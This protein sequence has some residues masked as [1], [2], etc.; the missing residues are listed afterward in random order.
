MIIYTPRFCVKDI[1]ILVRNKIMRNDISS[2][3]KGLGSLKVNDKLFMVMKSFLL[4]ML[5]LFSSNIKADD[6]SGI[7]LKKTSVHYNHNALLSTSIIEN[8]V[9]VDNPINQNSSVSGAVVDSYTGEPIPGALINIEGN[10]QST[11]T[12]S[13]GY[14]IL[15]NLIEGNINIEISSTGYSL[16]QKSFMLKGGTNVK[17]GTIKMTRDFDPYADDED[18]MITFD[19]DLFD[20]ESGSNQTIG[21]LSGASSDLYTR[22]SG[23]AFGVARFRYRGYDSRYTDVYINGLSFN[24]PSRGRFNFS[25][26]GGMN[27]AFRNK[28]VVNGADPSG[29]SFGDV[30]GATNIVT[31]AS[32]FAPGL[33][34]SV[35]YTNRNYNWRGMVTYSTGLLPNGWAMTASA[36]ARYAHEGAIDGTFYNSYG[37]FLSADKVLNDINTFSFTVFGSPTQR[38]QAAASYEECYRLTGNNLYNP[39]WGYQQ[40]KKRNARVVESFDPTFTFNWVW[41][42]LKNT[43]VNTG[44]GFRYSSYASTALN[45]YDTSDP[46]PDYYRRLPSYFSSNPSLQEYYTDQWE[47]NVDFRQINWDDLYQVNYLGRYENQMTGTDKG[48]T[49]IVEKRHSNQTNL[50]FGS[51]IDTD[52]NHFMGLQGGISFRWTKAD[53]YKT[54]DDLLG[55]EFWLDIDQFSESDFPDNSDILQNNM[56]NPNFKARKDDKFGY[57]YSIYNIITNLW[58]QNTIN[59]PQWEVYYG[60]SLR[61]YTFWRDGHMRN[62]RAPNNSYGKGDINQFINGAFKAGATYKFDGNNY[63]TLNFIGENKAPYFNNAYISAKI[64]DTTVPNLKSENIYSIDAS[65]RFAFNKLKGKVSAFYTGFNDQTE[66]S[67]F[68]H[69]A[70]QT[71]VNYILTGVKK[72]FKGLELGLSYQITPEIKITAVGTW[73]KYLYKNRPTGI[74]NYE[75]GSLPDTSQVVYLKNYHVGGTPQLAGNIGIN[76]KAPKLWFFEINLSLFEDAYVDLA[77][78][79]RTQ[80]ITDITL[81]GNSESEV[82]ENYN[83]AVNQL[84]HQDKLNGGLMLNVSIGKLI[85]LDR[86]NSLSINVT[87]NNITNNKNLQTGGYEQGRLPLSN[88][89]IDT[90]NLNKYPNKYYY[91]QGFNVFANVG[92]RF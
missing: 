48:S 25:A 36:I 86:K 33:R 27:N 77:P 11:T 92:Y 32:K 55:G 44:L 35:G 23:F 15:N 18:G 39:N 70:F 5:F 4:L 14:F 53:Y 43:T 58:I 40:G 47:N 57:N 19:E 42:P 28:N 91:S 8:A 13:K 76:W 88:G 9:P 45:W 84:K 46:R 90:S 78:I 75:N 65:Y 87:L 52:I 7:K 54:I 83:N 26:L 79:K 50:T 38:G 30:G 24:D 64:K 21:N 61:N 82:M 59:L 68:Y 89:K 20:D 37:L 41:T 74:T 29:F 60:L 16:V 81:T 80:A 71:Y 66:I 17:L 22:I 69:D 72:T 85:Y 2:Q 31:M 49:Y 67:S 10:V 3:T 73:A 63:F 12:D 62:G 1:K 56:N 51:T 34:A 6:N